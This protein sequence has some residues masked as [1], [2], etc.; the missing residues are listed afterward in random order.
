[1][2][3]QL[4][5]IEN[6]TQ[7]FVLSNH[8]NQ[9]ARL[10]NIIKIPVV[11]HV[12]YR[13]TQENISQ[14]QIQSQIDV[15]NADFRKLNADFSSTVAQFQPIAADMGIEFCLA[16]VDPNGAPTTGVERKSTTKTSWGTNDAMKKTSSGGLAAW[17]KD[18]YLNLWVCNIGGGILGYATFPGGTASL[19]GVVINTTA[20]GSTGYVTAPFNKGRTATH[21]IG[22]WLNL[23]HIWGDDGTLCSGSD[24]VTDTPNQSG[25]TYGCALSKTSCSGLNNTQNYMDYSD[26]RCL[27]MFTQGQKTRSLALFSANGVRAALLTSNGCGTPEPICPSPSLAISNITS[28]AATLS[29]SAVNTGTSYKIEYKAASSSTWIILS[30]NTTTTYNF[31]NLLACTNYNVRVTATCGSLISNISTVD[32]KTLGCPCATPTNVTATLSTSTSYKIAWTAVSGAKSYN[33][34]KKLTTATTW[35]T[36][37]GITTTSKVTSAANTGKQYEFQVQTVCTNGSTSEWSASVVV[38]AGQRL[39][40]FKA[41]VPHSKLNIYPNPAKDNINI[42]VVEGDIKQANI[43]L[44]DMT[45]RVILQ[46]NID[47]LSTTIHELSLSNIPNGIYMLQI[48]NEKE[49][50]QNT[51]IVKNE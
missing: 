27:T 8:D 16:T 31:T 37:T 18:K 24:L 45:G 11:V 47:L 17:P 15:L 35:T 21:E 1:M 41:V 30:N 5:E 2:I 39:E 49:L 42:E 25:P 33:L 7:N 44:I 23:R 36:I 20:F 10:A 51:R 22:H 9:N 26:D 3:H 40:E 4:E 14:A 50:I 32:F 6:Q 29:F 34:R 43:L 28:N 19:D 38:T 13:T 12:L 46:K 48:Q